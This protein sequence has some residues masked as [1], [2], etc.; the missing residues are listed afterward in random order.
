M[1]VSMFTVVGVALLGRLWLKAPLRWAAV[2]PAAGVMIGGAAML[3][4]P[5]IQAGPPGCRRCCRRFGAAAMLLLRCCLLLMLPVSLALRVLPF[6]PLP[7][8]ASPH[9]RSML[10]PAGWRG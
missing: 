1:L 8:C 6:P 10:P 5:D 4:V 7:S 9:R 3:L 2:A